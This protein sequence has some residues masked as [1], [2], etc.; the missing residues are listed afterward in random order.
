MATPASSAA[1]ARRGRRLRRVAVRRLG[2]GTVRRLAV[3]LLRG[4]ASV[5]RLRGLAIRRMGHAVGG[6]LRLRL[7]RSVRIPRQRRGHGS[8][9]RRGSGRVLPAVEA[10]GLVPVVAF[11]GGL[12]GCGHA[13]LLA[14]RANRSGVPG[15]RLRRGGIRPRWLRRARSPAAGTRPRTG[16]IRCS[17]ARRRTA[18]RS[19]GW[20][21]A[22]P[23]GTRKK[24]PSEKP[25]GEKN[26]W[27]TSPHK[28]SETPSWTTFPKT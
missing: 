24:T 10:A 17:S 22:R 1:R 11:V 5:R 8:A 15:S 14:S 4:L 27:Q 26:K 25:I 3:R 21:S 19:R 9:A 20:G 16:R 23:W 6:L 28:Q 2:C 7:L 13:M 18:C 12:L